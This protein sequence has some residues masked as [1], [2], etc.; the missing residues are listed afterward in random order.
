MSCF[1]AALGHEQ[2]SSNSHCERTRSLTPARGLMKTPAS[3]TAFGM[4]ELFKQFE[5]AQAITAK[6]FV[7]RRKCLK[8]FVESKLPRLKPD[9]IRML[10]GPSKVV[11]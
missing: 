11:P 3:F 5:I 1:L 2:Q 4:T 7:C 10:I 9:P 8:A 6:M